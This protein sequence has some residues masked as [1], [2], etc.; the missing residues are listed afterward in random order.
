MKERVPVDVRLR[1]VAHL[2][3]GVLLITVV[4]GIVILPSLLNRIGTESDVH[5]M[6]WLNKGICYIFILLWMVMIIV[7]LLSTIAAREATNIRITQRALEISLI[8]LQRDLQKMKNGQPQRFP[9][10]ICAE[11]DQ[12][13]ENTAAIYGLTG[14]FI[15][16]SDS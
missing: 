8:I 11:T 6:I 7:L 10:Q 12:R 9:Q 5:S 2:M 1:F 15:G 3:L 4:S 13:N 14:N 16:R